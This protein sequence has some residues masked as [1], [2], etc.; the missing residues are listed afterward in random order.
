MFMI[1]KWIHA[2]IHT[3]LIWVKISN[4][5]NKSYS[6]RKHPSQKLLAEHVYFRG[7]ILYPPSKLNTSLSP[8]V[9]ALN[10]VMVASRL[11]YLH[12]WWRHQMETFSALLTICAVNSPVTGEFP[13]QRPVPRGF[14][15]FFN[16][17][18]NKR[19]SKQSWGWCFEM[20]LRS[21]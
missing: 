3:I 5:S 13:T 12:T 4:L 2:F 11:N 1:Y 19:F 16:L 20:S 10:C 21:L 17:C 14:D 18:L 7:L 9:L 8:Q 6:Q 15:V